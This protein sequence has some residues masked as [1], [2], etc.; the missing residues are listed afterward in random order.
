MHM[1]AE[2]CNEKHTGCGVTQD[3][4][5]TLPGH[6]GSAQACASPLASAGLC[7]PTCTKL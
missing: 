6:S 3:R 7:F 4:I 2:E 1:G 5:Q